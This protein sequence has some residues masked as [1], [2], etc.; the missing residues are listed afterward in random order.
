LIHRRFLAIG[1]ALLAGAL[2]TA[3]LAATPWPAPLPSFRQ[4]AAQIAEPVVL[5]EPVPAELGAEPPTRTVTTTPITPAT[6]QEAIA[7]IADPQPVTLTA[8]VTENS[9]AIAE[10]LVWRI[11]DTKTD[12]S[13]QLA[14]AARS[15]AAVA[16]IE[17]PPGNYV[18]H[19]AYGR[20][21]ATDTLSVAEGANAKSVIL[22]AGGLRLN[23]AISGDIPIPINL[24]RFDIYTA[25]ATESDRTMAAQNLGANDI[26]I[27]NAGTYHVVSYFGAINAVVRADLRVEPGQLTDATLYHKAAQVSFRLVGVAG[28]EAIAD[29]D[30]TVKT[31][32]GATVFS[33]IGAFPA[34]AL[35]E[36]DYLVLAKRGDTVFNREFQVQAGQPRDIEVLTTVY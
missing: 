4:P 2:V 21:Q 23:A 32:D 6:A 33:E 36:G 24:L 30:W 19:A 18:V 1:S 20:A 14:L 26:V 35:R 34:T 11:F 3:S 22:E 12:N 15:D 31:A 17:L 9:G 29:V 27:L 5:E 25:G 16:H 28:G 7:T 10:G 8:Q 13:G